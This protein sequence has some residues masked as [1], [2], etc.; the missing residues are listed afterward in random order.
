MCQRLWYRF[1][2]YVAL[3][4][5]AVA[6]RHRA[7]WRHRIPAQGPV[8]LASNHQSYLDPIVVA[9]GLARLTTFM[10]RRSLFRNP[11][12]GWFIRSVRA[13]PISREGRDT[14]AMRKAI[15]RLESGALLVVFPEGTR[16]RDGKTGPVRGGVDVLARRTR[17]AVVPTRVVGAFEAMPRKGKGLSFVP[18]MVGFAEPIGPE[19]LARLSREALKERI[20]EAWVRLQHAMETKRNAG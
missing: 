14:E 1:W 4:I 16:S 11:V 19:D 3:I 20:Q 18:V 5:A 2:Q 12:F 6:F 7:Y 17:A 15:R 8:I 10:A 13:F 9:A